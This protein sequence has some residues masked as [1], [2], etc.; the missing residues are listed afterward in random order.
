[1]RQPAMRVDAAA[2]PDRA[3][4]IT[5]HQRPGTPSPAA[6]ATA[7]AAEPSTSIA[8]MIC[9]RGRP[10]R[11]RDC[12]NSLLAMDIPKGVSPLLVIVENDDLPHCQSVVVDLRHR[13]PA[14]WEINYSHE[15]RLGIPFARNR[16][17]EVALEMDADWLAFLDDDEIA[18]PD[19]LSAMHA[20][21]TKFDVDV[22]QGPVEYVYPETTPAWFER[23]ELRP[24]QS[25]TPLKTAYT[26]N[27]M[28]RASIA[29]ADGLN[30]RFDESLRFT[31]GSDTDYYFRAADKGAS[32]C[33]VHEALVKEP[34]TQERMTMQWQVK[35][36]M[37]VAA[38]A[39]TIHSRRFGVGRSLLRYLPKAL[40]RI[41]KGGVM[42]TVG[43]LGYPLRRSTASRWFYKG[44]KDLFSGIGG[45]AAF[46]NIKPQ[47]YLKIDGD[48]QPETA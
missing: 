2:D 21:S 29:R 41:V 3:R 36:A 6:K 30:L 35:R 33:W 40:T 17:L 7:P 46:L 45:L 27:V 20:A 22:L 4:D 14:V 26:N 10:L 39:S 25:G 16:A 5:A 42:V 19:W 37:R 8:V 11:L 34:V 38:N 1:M 15:P 23:K 47:P 9:T 43:A 13:A 28:M 44:A 48:P 32:L 18:T 12:V 31:G 24:R